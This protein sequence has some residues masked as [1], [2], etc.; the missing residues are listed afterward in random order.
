M[1]AT[2]LLRLGVNYLEYAHYLIDNGKAD[3]LTRSSASSG[4]DDQDY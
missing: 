2:V 1:T 4:G 3:E